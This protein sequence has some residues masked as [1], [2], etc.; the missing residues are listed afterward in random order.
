MKLS[1]KKGAQAVK[2]LIHINNKEAATAAAMRK[3][4]GCTKSSLA[5]ALISLRKRGMVVRHKVRDFELTAKAL[6]VMQG[7]Q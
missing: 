1:K 2:L 6:A 5:K 7:L 3:A 4:T